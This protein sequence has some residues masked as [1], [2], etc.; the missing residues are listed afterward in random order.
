MVWA[1]RTRQRHFLESAA[2]LHEQVP[3]SASASAARYAYLPNGSIGRARSMTNPG[4]H[5]N[6]VAWSEA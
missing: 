3:S 6:N 4:A 5:A 2:G 1:A